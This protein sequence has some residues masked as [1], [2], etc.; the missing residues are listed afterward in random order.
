[1]VRQ[2]CAYC[3]N[4][5]IAHVINRT[6]LYQCPECGL[7]YTDGALVSCCQQGGP[8]REELA[9]AGIGQQV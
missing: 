6:K 2:N 8:N 5:D 4:Y 1:M 7:H 3:Y 9:A